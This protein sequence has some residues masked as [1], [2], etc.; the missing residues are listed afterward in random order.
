MTNL[1][2][3]R[4]AIIYSYAKREFFPTEQQYIS[5]AEVKGR[6]KI[7][8]TYLNKMGIKT[9]LFPG[10]AKIIHRLKLFSPDFV[11]N[12]VDS[13]FGQE[14]LSAAIPG[15]LELLRIPYTGCGMMAQTLNSNK[16]LTRNLLEQWGLTIPKYQLIKNVTDEINPQLDYP[17][18]TKL[19]EIHGSIEIDDTAVC[20]DKKQ[21]QDRINFLINTY[22]QPVLL[23]EFIMGREIT[24]IVLEGLNTKVYA[25]EKI[26]NPDLTGKYQIASFDAVWSEDNKYS[27]AI[28]YQKYELPPQ[29]KDQIKTAFDILKMEDYAKFD[30]R[31]DASGRHYFIDANTNPALGPL[32]TTCA[33]SSV[34][35]LYDISFEEILTR[36]I[37]NTLAANQNSIPS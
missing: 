23:E 4:I 11:I 32:E 33:I 35:N 34:L 28:S 24:V 37:N 18:I 12:L 25:A 22:H 16:Y 2:P 9:E 13:V 7:I 20:Q 17:I 10:T 26:L 8:A 15:A 19:N 36:L 21:L 5:E 29:V 6:A 30:L 27:S 1:L 14:Y 31:L 3:K